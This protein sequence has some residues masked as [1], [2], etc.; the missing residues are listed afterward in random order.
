MKQR[1][2]AAIALCV[3]VG[4]GLF[5][6]ALYSLTNSGLYGSKWPAMAIAA[7]ALLA[8]FASAAML[9]C[10]L[11]ALRLSGT[12]IVVRA[13][14][15]GLAGIA[16]ALVATYTFVPVAVLLKVGRFA[17]PSVS[18]ALAQTEYFVYQLAVHEYTVAALLLVL[19]LVSSFVFLA[20]GRATVVVGK[21][22]A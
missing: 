11:F 17:M 19:V 8:I 13:L 20:I 22:A 3:F 10:V 18:R 12:H 5:L 9:A 15:A 4:S 14:V 1:S 16:S 6:P 21:N 2:R 7:T